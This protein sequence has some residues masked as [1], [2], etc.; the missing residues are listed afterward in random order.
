VRAESQSWFAPGSPGVEAP[1]IQAIAQLIQYQDIGRTSAQEG[2]AYNMLPEHMVFEWQ[3]GAG[4]G[5]LESGVGRI[6]IP[7]FA[8]SLGSGLTTEVS[9]QNV[10]PQPGFTDYVLLIYDQNGLVDSVCQKLG[11][12]E[13]EYVDLANWA[14]LHPGFRGSAVISAT[15]WEHELQLAGGAARNLVGLAAVRVER[16]GT[17]L[18]FPVPGDESA[19]SIGFPLPGGSAPLA[20]ANCRP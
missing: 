12:Y 18:G 19:A 5:G 3:L 10:V 6:A 20:A 9:I 2:M 4:R 16:S 15:F 14:Y 17:T 8:R 1:N 7:T 11:D 13:V